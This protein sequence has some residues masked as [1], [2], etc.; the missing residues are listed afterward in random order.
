MI[1]GGLF[2]LWRGVNNE[3]PEARAGGRDLLSW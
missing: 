2:V 3:C 1:S